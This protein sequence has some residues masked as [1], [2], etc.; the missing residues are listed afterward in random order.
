[1][2]PLSLLSSMQ[3]AGTVHGRQCVKRGQD[4]RS[5]DF[6]LRWRL[7]DFPL[8]T[9]SLCAILAC[10]NLVARITNERFLIVIFIM[11]WHASCCQQWQLWIQT[12]TFGG[13]ARLTANLPWS[14]VHSLH[15]YGENVTMNR[16][17]SRDGFPLLLIRFL[18]VFS[19]S[20]L[21]PLLCA[22][23]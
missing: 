8:S 11:P 19:L 13:P 20:A 14:W 1:M 9:L 6:K 10:S 16:T 17:L 12:V 21:S 5:P 22:L 2:T 18:S 4:W 3:V 23:P 7:R 15:A